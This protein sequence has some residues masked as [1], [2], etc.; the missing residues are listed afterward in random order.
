MKRVALL[1]LALAAMSVVC[2][3]GASS[4][5]AQF[6]RRVEIPPE[7][8]NAGK[9][10]NAT[11]TQKAEGQPKN[12]ITIQGFTA[13]L[14]QG[15]FCAEVEEPNT[16][17][18]NNALCTLTGANSNFIRVLPRPVWFV[19]GEQLKQGTKQIKLQIKGSAIL[20]SSTLGIEISCKGSGSE[21]ATIE[22]NGIGQGQGKGRVTYSQ[23]SV[24]K[25]VGKEGTC[26]VAQPI[27]TNQ[28]KTY[29]A[30]ANVQSKIVSVFEPT[31][32]K[33]FVELKFS[34]PCGEA[35]SS[36]PVGVT[37]NVAGEDIP[38]ESEGQ[39]GLVAFPA[40]AISKVTNEGQEKVLKLET[41][42]NVSTFTGAYSARLQGNERFAVFGTN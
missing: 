25:P 37:G 32:G 27:T 35:L 16:G 7:L 3:A 9:W 23:C 30:T 18:F 1:I 34:K 13:Y 19:G 8:E 11:C 17:H 4:S 21:G 10:S 22:G 28:L 40:T 6:C 24:L 38:S 2:G 5:M 31:V 36:S 20:K 29:L 15:Q 26:E 14:G 41:I 39:E 33:V 12:W 42:G